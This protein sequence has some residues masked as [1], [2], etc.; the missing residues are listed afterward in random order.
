MTIQIL[1]YALSL[2]QLEFCRLGFPERRLQCILSQKTMR[3]YRF[4]DPY[5]WHL[6]E[7]LSGIPDL[8]RRVD[9][10]VRHTLCH[11]LTSPPSP[12]SAHCHPVYVTQSDEEMG[13]DK[14][15]NCVIV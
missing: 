12:D 6:S 10:V 5:K 4:T 1:H 9:V 15:D 14:G 11:L 7:E 8:F 3:R 2:L 13:L